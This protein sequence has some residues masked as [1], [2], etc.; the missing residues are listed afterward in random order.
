MWELSD[1]CLWVCNH[2]VLFLPSI[3]T[4]PQCEDTF[5]GIWRV[6]TR[7]F[8]EALTGFMAL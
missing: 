6:L 3:V 1:E 5:H 4:L 8:L 2:L 7:S